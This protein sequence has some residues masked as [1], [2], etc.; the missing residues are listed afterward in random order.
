MEN[1]KFQRIT[2]QLF[3]INLNLSNKIFSPVKF[4][5]QKIESL[6]LE[7][8]KE[9]LTFNNLLTD[10]MIIV[11]YIASLLYIILASFK[12]SMLMMTI[13]NLVIST[14]L[15]V[16]SNVSQNQRLISLLS[17]LKI[18]LINLNLNLKAI[19]ISVLYNT[20]E[21]DNN[22][23]IMRVIIY[24]YFS[25]NL[26]ILVK[27]E[28]HMLNYI[29]YY[30]TNLITVIIAEIYS[31][32][33]HYYYL[34]AFT[35]FI[36]FIIFY[37][38]RRKWDLQSRKLFS[39]KYKF[40][41]L[42]HYSIDFIN[43]LNGY[44]INLKNNDIIYMDNR[45]KEL[46]DELDFKNTYKLN[47]GFNYES[48]S[49][50]NI[51]E[52]EINNS[53]PGN[54]NKKK[55]Y[56]NRK[57]L[58]NKKYEYFKIQNN[59]A[60]MNQSNNSIKIEPPINLLL[61]A[62]KNNKEINDSFYNSITKDKENEIKFNLFLDSLYYFEGKKVN[63]FYEN[64]FNENVKL[65][66]EET[67]LIDTQSM[68]EFI[69]RDQRILYKRSISL[70][71]N[72]EM[73][74]SNNIKNINFEKSIFLNEK[75]KNVFRDRI[76]EASENEDYLEIKDFKNIINDHDFINEPKDG[77]DYTRKI[78]LLEELKQIQ[79]SQIYLQEKFTNL[80]I[81]YFIGS[82]K[83]NDENLNNNVDVH[84]SNYE[85]LKISNNVN[86]YFINKRQYF[87]VFLRRIRLNEQDDLICD[88][89]FYDITEL[90]TTR[91]KIYE[92][93]LQKQKILAKIGQDF[94]TALNSIIG[95]VNKH[96]LE[97]EV[98][99]DKINPSKNRE[100]DFVNFQKSKIYQ[101]DNLNSKEFYSSNE[102][103]H[104]KV[105]QNIDSE[106]IK[107]FKDD[108]NLIRN[109]SNYLNL[110][111]SD[112]IQCR[113]NLADIVIH[114]SIIS[115]KDLIK[116]CSEILKILINSNKSKSNN[117]NVFLNLDQDIDLMHILSDEN[118]IKQILLNFISNSV[119][120]T[121]RGFISI[122]CSKVSDTS[123]KLKISINDSGIGIKE[124]RKKIIFIDSDSSPESNENL[125]SKISYSI[126]PFTKNLKRGYGLNRSRVLAKNLECEVGFM[127][128]FGKGST[129]YL[130]IPYFIH[131]EKKN[132]NNQNEINFMKNIQN[133]QNN[134]KKYSIK[135]M[136]ECKTDNK[137]FD[138]EIGRSIKINEVN[139]QDFKING[140]ESGSELNV[141]RINN[142]DL[143][144]LSKETLILNYTNLKSDIKDFKGS[145]LSNTNEIENKVNKLYFFN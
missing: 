68:M 80:G 60:F 21:D 59:S 139:E 43:G 27:L 3:N 51:K 91:L 13:I 144:D 11:G 88:I 30:I 28:S 67:D 20:T 108:L 40:E 54:N 38:L 115:V 109:L 62:N 2:Q 36:L 124:E 111:A 10:T 121:Q 132:Y 79:S 71:H 73:Q 84:P 34:D 81:Y 117:I 107:V 1:F 98:L 9:R 135:N 69:D 75:S 74:I 18:F 106:T 56:I 143:N 8:E 70:N 145:L 48:N 65:L 113:E 101:L 100:D 93:S 129:F 4:E 76:V 66:K 141:S 92:E 94:K 97:F 123:E 49:E 23:E 119:K 131:K 142:S 137:N 104:L 47:E 140:I 6:Y 44:H 120:F 46:Y 33:K 39:E 58:F 25:T 96:F 32:K 87:D 86:N 126:E 82:N 116:F 41:K 57:V 95:I 19:L 138:K 114:K 26:F 29:F 90:V 72:E 24:D 78:S 53:I 89:L 5:D 125:Y 122:V 17:H 83:S 128:E 50:L 22:E 134:D 45:F 16:I 63:M 15:I 35:G 61:N 133:N 55:N 52:I 103:G 102:V 105:K 112:I 31:S 127:S 130:I 42:Y 14:F 12:Q 110:L 7:D 77:S 99:E 136:I 85:E 64:L 37:I 118:R